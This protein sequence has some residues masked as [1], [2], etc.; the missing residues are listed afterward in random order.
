M[1]TPPLPISDVAATALAR[2]IRPLVPSAQVA[3][4]ETLAVIL[5][6]LPAPLGDGQVFRLCRALLAT[7][8]YPLAANMVV[9]ED[10]PGPRAY[11]MRY[12][13]RQG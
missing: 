10:C 8:H 1:S 12:K 4:V 11:R 6:E 5:R 2:Q 9:D 13:R 7:G 3:L